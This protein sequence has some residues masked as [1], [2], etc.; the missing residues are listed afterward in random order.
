MSSN[1]ERGL[2]DEPILKDE[3]N[4]EPS[5]DESQDL[6]FQPSSQKSDSTE[7]R[8]GFV[9][10]GIQKGKQVK[11]RLDVDDSEVS[12][13]PPKK[14]GKKQKHS[15][16]TSKKSVKPTPSSTKARASQWSKIFS[17]LTFLLPRR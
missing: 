8:G 13:P 4:H 3:P 11:R 9:P 14:K 5:F 6:N 7:A 1:T 12:K 10:E 16:A 2:I 17:L 15:P